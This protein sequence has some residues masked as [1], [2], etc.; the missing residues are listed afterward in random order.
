MATPVVA[1]TAALVWG[2]FPA[3]TRNQ[4]VTRLITNGKPISKGFAATT[5]RVDV[6]KAITG[7]SETALV[8]R[9]LDPFTALAPSPPTTPDNA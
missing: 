4:L 7:T 1:G 9:L 3:L 5:R 6:R 8:G 2:Q